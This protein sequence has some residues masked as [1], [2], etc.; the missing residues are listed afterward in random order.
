MS[1][2][3]KIDAHMY[4]EEINYLH[5]IYNSNITDSNYSRN[6]FTPVL[7]PISILK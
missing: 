3:W 6:K 5:S 1:E 4:C 2:H 7:K